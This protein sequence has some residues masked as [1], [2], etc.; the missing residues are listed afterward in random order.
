MREVHTW[1]TFRPVWPT[2][3]RCRSASGRR[4]RTSRLRPEQDAAAT[5]YTDPMQFELERERVLNTYVAARRPLRTARRHRR[6]AE[7]R[8]PWRDDRHRPPA[9]GAPRRLPQRVLH[10]GAAF[11]TEW[12]GCGASEFKCPYHGW[13]YD[14]TGKVKGVPERDRLRS[15]A[16]QGPAQPA[17][18]RRRVGRVGMGQPCRTRRRA[19]AASRGSATRSSPISVSTRWTTW[20][21][22]TCS[23]GTC[24]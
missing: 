2:N 15:R 12:Q 17:G 8:E 6:L 21:C 7:L 18:R 3:A 4:C 9:R 5:P 10:R 22:S 16:P 13:S 23:S 1:C 20:C 19:V 11:V 24:R 14:L